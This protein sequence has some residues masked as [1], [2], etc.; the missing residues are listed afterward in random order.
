[1]VTVLGVEA[2]IYSL[3]KKKKCYLIEELNS[4]DFFFLVD[5]SKTPAVVDFLLMLHGGLNGC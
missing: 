5:K 1:M 4:W 3:G 2:N